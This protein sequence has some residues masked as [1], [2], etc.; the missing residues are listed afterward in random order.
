VPDKSDPAPDLT[1]LTARAGIDE[2]YSPNFDD[3]HNRVQLLDLGGD[4][5][6]AKVVMASPPH[7]D[8]PD[9]FDPRRIRF[10]DLDGSGPTDV[11]YVG[12]DVVTL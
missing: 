5:K 1:A 12:P 4:G 10:A 2:S 11:V 8:H 6:R 7:F 3:D 9:R